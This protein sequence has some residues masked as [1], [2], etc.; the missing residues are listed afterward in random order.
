MHPVCYGDY[1][2]EKTQGKFV[3]SEEKNRPVLLCLGLGGWVII[4]ELNKMALKNT[5]LINAKPRL[6][7]GFK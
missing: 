5:S 2:S 4:N 7:A 1:N 6:N 3:M